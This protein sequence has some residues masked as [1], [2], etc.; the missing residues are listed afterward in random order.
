MDFQI[1]EVFLIV[2]ESFI[3]AANCLIVFVGGTIAVRLID[4]KENACV[5]ALLK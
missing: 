1:F 5:S 2:I 4:H 3:P